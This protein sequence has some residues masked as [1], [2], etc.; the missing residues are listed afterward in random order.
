[1]DWDDPEPELDLSQAHLKQIQNTL[2]SLFPAQRELKILVWSWNT[3][4]VRFGETATTERKELSFDWESGFL[5][6]CEAPS[7][8][9][10]MA[11]RVEQEQPHLIA[12]G[13]QE[14]AKPGS[15]WLSSALPP[16]LPGYELLE[17]TRL[18]GVGL[19]T[20]TKATAR[21]LRLAVFVRSEWAKPSSIQCTTLEHVCSGLAS[22]TR[23]KGGAAILLDLPEFGRLVIAN[24]HLP[25]DSA[26]LGNW[27]SR[28]DAV[29]AQADYLEELH[30]ALVLGTGQPL[31]DHVI[32]MGD[33]NFRINPFSSS[34]PTTIG[35]QGLVDRVLT[36]L[37]DKGYPRVYQERD[38]LLQVL[39]HSDWLRGYR[40]GVDDQGPNFAP[41]CKLRKERPDSE[42]F[43]LEWLQQTIQV[44][45]SQGKRGPRTPGWADRILFRSYASRHGITAEDD[46]NLSCLA[47]ERWDL[48]R[49]SDHAGVMALLQLKK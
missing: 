6:S 14:D 45:A 26:S 9:N 41:T 33:L 21:G 3:E 13:L 8:V 1:M 29:Q 7:F 18:I 12:I 38:E 39:Q 17:K 15:Y 35:P 48:S 20:L 2:G 24:S 49:L 19:T 32:F 46:K 16:L 4:S 25:F 47:Y 37:I 10:R 23:G 42:E 11:E 34:D 44:Q 5:L 27:K 30:S 36:E 40:E 28:S 31:P 43:S 22:W